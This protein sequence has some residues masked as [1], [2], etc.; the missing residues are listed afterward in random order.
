MKG[1]GDMEIIFDHVT[2]KFG[3]HGA[4]KDFSATLN[5]PGV[6][7]LIGP[8]GA[9]KPTLVRMLTTQIKPTKG[10]ILLNGT[11]IVKHPDSLWGILGYLPQQIPYYP[12]LT[13]RSY[14]HYIAAAKR[15]PRVETDKQIERL[16]TQLHLENIHGR[17]LSDY[18]GGMRQRVA[19]A[20]SLLGDPQLIVCDEPTVG[21]D[22]IERANLR[23]LYSQL[24]Q[25]RLVLMSTHIISDIESVA[26]RILLMRQGQLCFDGTPDEAITAT[27]GYV[28]EVASSIGHP[29]P[30]IPISAMRQVGQNEMIRFI[31]DCAVVPGAKQVTPTLED[32]SLAI[33]EGRVTIH[34]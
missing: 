10:D 26:N 18:S 12:E 27:Q 31:A 30:D 1:C 21:L 3:D 22:P 7:G 4:V 25:T 19:I 6:V 2:M 32:A 5:T 16:L 28:W 15:L 20:A 17:R 11:S 9:G 33:L 8:N 34:A 14:L 29:L 23:T 13:A 24:A